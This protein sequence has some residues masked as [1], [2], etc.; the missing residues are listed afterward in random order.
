MW[1]HQEGESVAAK[2]ILTLVTVYVS[3]SS[4]NNYFFFCYKPQAEPI[5][6]NT[7]FWFKILSTDHA[8][9]TIFFQQN[10]CFSKSHKLNN[11]IHKE[12]IK[13]KS[14]FRKTSYCKMLILYFKLFFTLRLLLLILQSPKTQ[15]ITILCFNILLPLKWK[16]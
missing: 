15:I 3:S 2:T 7:S 14:C 11:N 10:Q 9:K 5:E 4:T 12:A 6:E 1:I 13:N 16:I 8:H